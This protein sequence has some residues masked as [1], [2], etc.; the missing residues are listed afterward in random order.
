MNNKKSLSSASYFLLLLSIVICIITLLNQNN[1]WAPLLVAS[2][3]TIC[4]V[5]LGTFWLRLK[6]VDNYALAILA[7]GGIVAS[8][9]ATHTESVLTASIIVL[10]LAVLGIIMNQSGAAANENNTGESKMD[11]ILE[12]VQMSENAKRVLFRDR[13]LSVLR[14]T[15]QEDIA[16]GDF[17]AA[18]VL[19]EQMATVFGAVEEAEQMR[20][21]VQQII[22]RH[23]ENR[24]RE[25][26]QQLNE[27][28]NSHKWVEAYQFSA[29]LRR[30]FPESPLLHGLEQSIADAR[31]EY[32][33]NLEDRFLQA[34]QNENVEK[35]MILL[36]EL[37]GYLTPEE[38]RRFRDTATSVITTYRDSLGVRFKMAVSDHRWQDAIDFGQE[39]IRQFPNIKMAEEASEILETIQVRAVEDETAT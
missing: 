35:A 21:Q 28:L 11:A 17:H 2:I 33:H 25:E 31:T 37:D 39:I 4:C 32:S 1:F 30:L 29:R 6:L 18:L 36:R 34:A 3:V 23:H 13:E 20:T 24:I 27:L 14:K 19:C 9:G 16:N 5:L 8:S 10:G 12:A 22:H 26:V 15:V 7:V 38:A